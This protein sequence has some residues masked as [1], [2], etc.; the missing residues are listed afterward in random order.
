MRACAHSCTKHAH[1]HT[2]KTRMHAHTHTHTHTNTH[3]HTHRIE[4]SCVLQ[5]TAGLLADARTVVDRAREEAGYYRSWYSEA[6]PVKVSTQG[7]LL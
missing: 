4:V 7:E 5:A 2:T 3:T 6:I 1:T